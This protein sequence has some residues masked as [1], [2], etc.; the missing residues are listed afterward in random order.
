MRNGLLAV[1]FTLLVAAIGATAAQA[2]LPQVSAGYSVACGVTRA[3]DAVCWG[4]DDYGQATVPADLGKV[5]QVSAGFKH[6]CALTTAQTVRC[7]GKDTD[8]FGRAGVT[9]VPG[10]LG[11]VTVVS[12][13]YGH[14]CAVKTS[15]RS[16]AGATRTSS[17][18]R[19]HC[20]CPVR[21]RP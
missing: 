18:S 10:D 9:T 3:S 20:A 13:G 14:T 12:A 2:A 21:P 4:A 8:R 5:T 1:L 17:R 11:T 16:R 6:A 15:G 7:W 19:T